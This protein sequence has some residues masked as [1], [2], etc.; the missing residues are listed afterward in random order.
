MISHLSMSRSPCWEIFK[1]YISYIHHKSVT[2]CYMFTNYKLIWRRRS[3]T[4]KIF[5]QRKGTFLPLLHEKMQKSDLKVLL[6]PHVLTMHAVPHFLTLDT[7]PM[8]SNPL[9][10]LQRVIYDLLERYIL[11]PFHTQLAWYLFMRW[12]VSTKLFMP[13]IPDS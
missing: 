2:M 5:I 3:T 8:I 13:F 11:I 6:Y 9:I 1:M 7:S 12:S 4:L 10:E